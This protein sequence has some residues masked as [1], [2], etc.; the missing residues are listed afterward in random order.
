MT[1][2]KHRQKTSSTRRNELRLKIMKHLVDRWLN[3]TEEFKLAAKLYIDELIADVRNRRIARYHDLIDYLCRKAEE[4]I[5][6]NDNLYPNEKQ[7]LKIVARLKAELIKRWSYFRKPFWPG[8]RR[9][10]IL[11]R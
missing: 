4:R 7:F 1:M 10:R 6:D 9:G 3:C 8:S 2:K 11:R 5:E